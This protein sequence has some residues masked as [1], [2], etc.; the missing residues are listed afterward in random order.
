MRKA[1]PIALKK[2]GLRWR[3][4]RGLTLARFRWLI[5]VLLAGTSADI[6]ATRDGGS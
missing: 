1:K 4:G 5:V 6:K 2:R 3:L